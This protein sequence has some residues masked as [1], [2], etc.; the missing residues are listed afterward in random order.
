[1]LLGELLDSYA[2]ETITDEQVQRVLEPVLEMIRDGVF[3]R[4][5]LRR[6]NFVKKCLKL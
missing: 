6:L 5:H 4:R 1:M 2:E 3:D